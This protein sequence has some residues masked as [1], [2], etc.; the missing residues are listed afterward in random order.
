VELDP[1]CFEASFAEALARAQVTRAS[2][3]VQTFDPAIQNAIGRVQPLSV[4]ETSVRYL[5]EAGVSSLNFDLMY[6]LPRQDEATLLAS[7]QQ[8]EELG[9]DRLAV[10]GYAH[11][12]HLLSRQRRIEADELPTLAQRFRMAEMAHSELTGRG[13]QSVGFDHF[14]RTCDPLAL[15]AR[16][17]R[18]RRNFQGFT[19]DP[20]DVLI[21]FGASAISRLPGALVQNDKNNGS[22]AARLALGGLPGVRGIHRT[23]AQEAQG[24]I[25]ERLLCG[26]SIALQPEPGNLTSFDVLAPFFQRGL[27]SWNGRSLQI[28][29]SALP[30][31]RVIASCFDEWRAASPVLLSSAI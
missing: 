18:L 14:A 3:G 16:E 2:L 20:C 13:W 17:N 30:Y 25:I 19:D 1:R 28:S 9:A 23:P 10:F 11:V 12:P 29:D 26:G 5:R 24:R 21:G 31:A 4:V 8:S 22:Y 15:A 27:A 6:G 7:L